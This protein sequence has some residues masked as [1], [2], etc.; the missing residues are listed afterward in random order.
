MQ[1][2][3]KFYFIFLNGVIIIFKKFPVNQGFEE[4]VATFLMGSCSISLNPWCHSWSAA[5]ISAMLYFGN[6]ALITVRLPWGTPCPLNAIRL[7]K[8][9][10][11]LIWRE[12]RFHVMLWKCVTLQIE[13]NWTES[14]RMKSNRIDSWRRLNLCL[15]SAVWSATI[16]TTS[17][18]DAAYCMTWN[19][20]S[21]LSFHSFLRHFL[22]GLPA[23]ENTH[24][25]VSAY[26][27]SLNISWCFLHVHNLYFWTMFYVKVICP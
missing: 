16:Q 24:E 22:S 14:N 2:W 9:D 27:V 23:A 7:E 21:N 3:P 12:S 4:K 25:M 6:H 17:L 18:Q 13:L 5:H 1:Q 20:F 26:N 10:F 8:T 11:G 15:A 19:S